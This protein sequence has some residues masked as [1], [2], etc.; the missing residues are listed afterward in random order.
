MI[1]FLDDQRVLV[2]IHQRVCLVDLAS[3][4]IEKSFRGDWGDIQ[5]FTLSPDARLLMACGWHE[6]MVRIWD[7][8]TGALQLEIEQHPERLFGCG[9]SPDGRQIVTG[10]RDGVVRTFDATTGALEQE[11]VGHVGRIWST[12]FHPSGRI[13][14]SAGDG[15]VR[16]WN[17]AVGP[18]LLGTT[19]IDLPGLE[20]AQ[21][22]VDLGGGQWLVT[23]RIGAAVVLGEGQREVARIDL[24]PDTETV[25][26]VVDRERRRIA[27]ATNQGPIVHRFPEGGKC[28][29][30][31]LAQNG[32]DANTVAFGRNG[33]LY[34]AARA[35][36]SP[37][38]AWSPDLTTP[39]R[40]KVGAGDGVIDSV[41]ATTAP[42]PRL[43]MSK[44]SVITLY[45]LNADGAPVAGSGRQLRDFGSAL[46]NKLHLAWSPD[47]KRL[48]VGSIGGN[49]LI[50]DA[51]SG[52]IAV[53]L[54]SF[55]RE[56]RGMLWADNGLA[57]IV[58]DDRCIRLCDAVSGA[59]LDEIR[60]GWA[61]N[62]IAFVE[63]S[64][65]RQRLAVTGSRLMIARRRDIQAIG[66]LPDDG[67]LLLLDLGRRLPADAPKK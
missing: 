43:A 50:V 22:T 24:G 5:A 60:P 19:L 53:E 48:A 47:G 34:A 37:L 63:G 6:R 9:F 31:L 30:P 54:S 49:A 11:I 55:A 36:S 51:V 13:V 26:S 38:V 3:G 28:G 23:P 40:L 57:L 12:F 2:A 65:Q 21:S 18:A 46:G 62:S 14:S 16:L 33:W 32:Y 7:V 64:D 10:C 66:N 41:V 39:Q 35:P 27:F 25:A 58:A 67:R 61:I 4:R 52:N 42:Q 45:D 17:P 29:E 56:V 15:T 44:S 59:T 1:R 8:E 20:T